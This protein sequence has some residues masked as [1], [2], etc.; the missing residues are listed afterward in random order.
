MSG[1]NALPDTLP[2]VLRAW[3]E[4]EIGAVADI[5][6]A[7][8]QL[9]GHARGWQL[10]RADRCR[11]FLKVSPH[12]VAYERETF[13]LR[14]AAPAL[15]GG[16]APQLR[17]SSA[18][19]LAIL[20]AAVPG[21]SVRELPLSSA[22]E[23]EAHRQGGLLLARLHAAGELTGRR[24]LEAEQA[25]YTAADGAGRLLDQAGGRLT[26]AEHRLVG[27]LTQQLRMA[28]PLRLGFIHGD[29]WPGNLLLWSPPSASAHAARTE[30]AAC[31]AWA[32][33]V[34]FE[35]S[36]FAP[37][38]QDFVRMACEVWPDR[39][40][41]RTAF[42]RGYG[43]ELTAQ[44]RHVLKCLAA[45]DAVRDLTRSEERDREQEQEKEQAQARARGRRTLDQLAA[46][47]FA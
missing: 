24:R 34:G 1:A 47:V 33:W 18:V 29:A 3:A 45:L 15:G 16:R 20:S 38:V 14:H 2:T 36:R 17:A 35:R 12:P 30:H 27:G 32:A 6:D 8:S 11:F 37:V 22:E 10:V 46:G 40:D 23:Y 28:G 5:R 4:D 13:A 21:R 25:L 31:A 9:R 39:P 43:R 7:A 44:E 19:H 26:S 41:L 42:F